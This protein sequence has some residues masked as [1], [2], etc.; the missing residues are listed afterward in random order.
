MAQ[1][2]KLELIRIDGGTQP[3]AHLNEATVAEYAEAMT[4]GAKL[5]PVTIYFDGSD[6]WLADGFHRYHAHRSIGALSIDADVRSGSRREAV[7]HSVGANASHGLRRT[8]DDKRRAVETLLG[9]AEWAAWTDREIA[10]ACGVSHT[11]VATIRRPAVAEKRQENRD[12]SAAKRI[13]SVEPGSTTPAKNSASPVEPDCTAAVT[14][15]AANEEDEEFGPSA[16]E[17]AF[18]EEK[19]KSD[20]EVFD[21]LIE[22]GH[23]D[24]ALGDALDLVMKQ[25]EEIARLRAALRGVEDSR[26]GLMNANN[27]HIRTIKGLRR[28]LAQ[29]EKAAA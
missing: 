22:V 23:S 24:D 8:N 3:R 16:E 2:V 28:K 13:A 19:E 18:F 20:R 26:N 6:Y 11:F 7:L 10:K 9:D 21:A 17:L 15:E 1:A 12:K 5:P 4:D 14:E 27:E 25:G 29:Y